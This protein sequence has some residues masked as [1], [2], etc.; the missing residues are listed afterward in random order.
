MSTAASFVNEVVAVCRQTPDGRLLDCNDACAVMLGYRDRDDL[1]AVGRLVYAN[2]S[3]L[4]AVMAAVEDLE[5]LS[6]VELA[7]TRKDGSVAWVLQNLRA[8]SED[9][10]VVALDMAMLDVTEQ[11]VATQ[12]FEHQALHDGVTGLPNR[13]LFTDRVSVAM[14]H[15]RRRGL[16]VAI[17]VV[18]IDGFGAL[19]NRHGRGYG[20]RILRAAGERIARTVREDDAVARLSADDFMILLSGMP[21]AGDAAI[22]ASRLASAF[23]EPLQVGGDSIRVTISQGI[24]IGDQDGEDIDSLIRHAAEA[25]AAASARGGDS[26]RFFEPEMNARALERAAMVARLRS[27]V[28]NGELE[29]HYQ[30]QVNVQT[31]KIGCIEA[32]LRWQHPDLGLIPS[33]GFL[34]AAEQGGLLGQIT[35]IVVAKALRQLREWHSIGLPDMRV[36]INLAGCQLGERNI[37]ALFAEAATEFGVSPSQIEIE[38]PE[39]AL[40]NRSAG[41]VLRAMKELQLLLAIDDFGT[42]GCSIT[43]LKRLPVDTIKI[44]PML[45]RNMIDH[46]DDAAIVQAMITMGRALDLRVIAEGVETKEQFSWLLKSRCNEMQGYFVARPAPALSFE[47]MLLMQNH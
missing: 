20:D 29:L 45:V 34:P 33:A 32:L 10:D 16:S 21:G 37:P 1:M 7:L 41:D 9:G 18:D 44:A 31:G 6:N 2:E 25:A 27:A 42:G 36:A 4:A 12:R 28:D 13:T 40:S 11:R 46:T 19:N 39:S 14:A 26:F 47:E 24:A 22:A 38:F 17:M 3:D 35:E 15:A 5:K 23:R 8:V 43:D 30:P